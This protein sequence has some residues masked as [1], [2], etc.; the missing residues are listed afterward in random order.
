MYNIAIQVNNLKKSYGKVDVVENLSFEVR[1]GEI[2]GLLGPNGAGKTTTLE[3]IEGVKHYD[4][5]IITIFG[6][7]TETSKFNKDIG[8]QLQS[9]SLHSSMTVLEAMKLFCV[10]QKVALRTDL[11]NNFGLKNLYKKQ[12]NTL[13]TGEKRRLH[14]AIAL[15]NDPKLLILDEPTAGLD[16][17]GR[18]HLHKE[19]RKLR[20]TGVTIILASHD[21]AEVESLCDRV[22]I[23]VKGEIIV[24]GTPEEITAA[25][26][27]DSKIMIKTE[28][29]LIT[30]EICLTRS[31]VIE[32]VNGYATILTANIELCLTELLAYIKVNNDKIIDLRVDKPSLEERF[33][34]VINNKEVE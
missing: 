19:I 25:S 26:Q 34:E 14:L 15:A 1:E 21:M 33:I 29:D 2:F 28:K 24:T 18:L 6:E 23:I 4:E 11:L 17:E 7:N 27:S 22:A 16:V 12:Y 10:W 31:Q 32:M 13:S 3:C 30:K 20:A 5:G 8:V 9:T